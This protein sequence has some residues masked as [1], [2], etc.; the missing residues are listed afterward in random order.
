MALQT[1]YPGMPN[2]PQTELAADISSSDTTI[3]VLNA[4][5]LPPA[6]NLAVIG[7]DEMAETV[8]Y[9]GI[10]GNNLTGVTRGFQGTARNWSA[11]AKV[12]RNFTAYDYDALRQNVEELDASKAPVTHGSAH[13]EFGADPIPLAT[14]TEGGLMS[15]A[16]KANLDGINNKLSGFINVKEFGAVG[17]GVTD[18]SSAVS[19]AYSELAAN[20]GGYLYKEPG[21]NYKTTGQIGEDNNVEPLLLR[22]HTSAGLTIQQGTKNA[23]LNYDKNPLLWVQKFTQHDTEGDRFSHNVG[24]G[25]F[26]VYAKGSRVPGT[27]NVENT[28]ISLLANTVLDSANMGTPTA[29]DWDAEGGVIGIAGFAQAK[30]YNRGIITALWGYAVSPELDDTTFDNLPAGEGFTTVGLEINIGIRHKDPGMKTIVSG[31]G[32]S[33]GAY[34]FN[35]RNTGSGV[36]DWTF[37]IA[38]NGSPDDGNYSGTD[39]NLWNGFHTGIL[40]DKIKDNG[41][42]FGRYF[43]NGSYG[44]RF[45]DS[46][47]GDNEPLYGIYMGNTKLNLGKYTGTTFNERDMWVY[48]GAAPNDKS[49]IKYR[50]GGIGESMFGSRGITTSTTFLQSHRMRIRVD[51]KE[52]YIPLEYIADV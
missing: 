40:L 2:S 41:I 6:P 48:D 35:Y 52:Y 21:K 24:G 37:G 5:A 51:G 45:P 30:G 9:T 10:D 12:A 11:G 17:D 33:V 25:F 1:M 15:A 28:W 18:D 34:I 38:F 32:T 50:R 36:R 22:S 19:A 39:I 16:D 46:F 47:V 44:I 23:P 14:P 27:Q 29:Q 13:T 49:N 8:L 42:L 7:S 26:E 3:P 20:G 31:H 4:A 43:K